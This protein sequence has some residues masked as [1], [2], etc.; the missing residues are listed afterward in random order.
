MAPLYESYR[1]HLNAPR[2]TPPFH[3]GSGFKLQEGNTRV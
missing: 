3:S 1:Q 2:R